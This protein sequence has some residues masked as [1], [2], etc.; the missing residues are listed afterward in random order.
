VWHD[1][2]ACVIWL[3]R[4]CG[5]THTYVWHDAHDRF[6]CV[7]WRIC[8]CDMTHSYDTTQHLGMSHFTYWNHCKVLCCVVR[9]SHVTH[10]TQHLTVIR[11]TWLIRNSL[12][13]VVLCRTNESCYTYNTTPYSHMYDM[14][15]SW[16]IRDSF[17]GVVLCRTNELCYTYKCV[18]AHTWIM[19][20][21]YDTTQRLGMIPYNMWNDSSICVASQIHLCVLTHSHEWH[22]AFVR[23]NAIPW[24]RAAK[25]ISLMLIP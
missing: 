21:S 19:T 10:T 17:Q 23:R 9:M 22:D 15:H 12:Q 24:Q 7:P 8:M 13:G 1:S 18:I 25:D 14:T 11:M 16:L 5:M 4:M 20:H 6:M 3:L 2:Y